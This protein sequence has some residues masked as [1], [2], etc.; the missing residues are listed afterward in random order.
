MLL[1]HQFLTWSFFPEAISRPCKKVVFF[2]IFFDKSLN[3]TMKK[4][5]MDIV[6]SYWDSS[7]QKS[8]VQYLTSKFQN[9]CS[10][11]DLNFCLN[12]TLKELNLK[13]MI[14]LAMD[15]SHVN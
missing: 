15:A 9:Y 7:A 14:Q 4:R 12:E 13:R 6:V 8:C 10:A 3:E 11:E 1:C 2:S 5:Q